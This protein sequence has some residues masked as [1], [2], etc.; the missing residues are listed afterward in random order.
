MRETP[1]EVAM[2]RVQNAGYMYA[3]VG[4]Y[5]LLEAYF[6]ACN[7]AFRVGVKPEELPYVNTLKLEK[8]NG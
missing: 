6:K 8:E 2:L 5:D 3:K 4:T 1:K 7:E